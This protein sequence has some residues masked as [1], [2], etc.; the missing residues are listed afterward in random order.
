[1]LI[2]S[3]A[4]VISGLAK[5]KHAS[6]FWQIIQSIFMAI[7]SLV[8]GSVP[9]ALTTA[10]AILRNVLEQKGLLNKNLKIAFIVVVTTISLA[11]NNCGWI[12]LLPI[13][14]FIIS[15]ISISLK[16][17][18]KFKKATALVNIIFFVNDML[19]YSFTSAIFNIVSMCSNLYRAHKTTV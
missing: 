5:T 3:C 13:I 1:M 19:I 14:A 12:G 16:D 9:A 6:L 18:S 15:T 2:G 7:G 17:V 11:A 10:F 4:K 8:L